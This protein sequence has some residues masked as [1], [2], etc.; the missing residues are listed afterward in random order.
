MSFSPTEYPYDTVVR[1]VSTIGGATI[2]GSG[3]LVAPDELLTASHVVYEAGVGAATSIVATPGYSAGAAPYGSAYGVNFHYFPINNASNRISLY[4]SQSDYALV[5]L[6]RSFADLGTMALQPNF[7]GGAVE[8]TGFPSYAN[9]L[10]ASVSQYVVRDATYTV[11]DGTFTGP[12]S[13]GGPVWVG[14][15][16]D[17]H[18]VGV[19]S[20][21]DVTTGTG[22][23][24][25]LT[26]AAYNLIEQWIAGDHP[27]AA[28]PPS[29]P[30]VNANARVTLSGSHT[31]Y[32]IANAAGSVFYNDQVSGRDGTQV[33]PGV[34]ELAFTDGY[35]RFDA[36]GNA[37][38]VARL[39]SAG[40]GRNAELDGLEYYTGLLDAGTLRLNDVAVGFVTSVEFQNTYGALDD[41]SFVQRIYVNVLGRPASATEV[42]F[43]TGAIARGVSRA[44]VLTSFSDSVENKLNL[45]TTIGDK[46]YGEAYRLYQAAFDRTP[47]SAGLANAVGVL[48]N[49]ASPQLLALGFVNSPEFRASFTGLSQ[50]ATVNKLYENVLHR[51]G[52]AA[53]IDLWVGQLQSGASLAQV[54]IG[55]S[56][57]LENRIATASATHDAWVYTKT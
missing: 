26:T 41:S 34:L 28:L 38:A 12:G 15:E 27:A 50:A 36:T 51:A 49:G 10:M 4:D 31:Q 43:W 17:P 25:L 48:D 22:Y 32:T 37:G 5:H 18:V 29:R 20:T 54:L 46:D 47:D 53:G 13:S 14:G 33:R 1:V 7:G 44:S 2:Q 3:V 35:G 39:Y 21:G 16:S 40:L 6:S 56:D 8:V 45:A 9:G 55:F 52:E 57:S 11:L 24:T 42:Q 23:F 30:Q 19:V